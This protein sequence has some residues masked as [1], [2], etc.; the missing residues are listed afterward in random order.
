MSYKNAYL[1]YGVYIQ[2]ETFIS[3]TTANDMFDIVPL[4]RVSPFFFF[5]FFFHETSFASV[6]VIFSKY[7]LCRFWFA[8]ICTC[9]STNKKVYKKNGHIAVPL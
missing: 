8:Y 3:T 5:V 6:C 1:I 4:F 9:V 2:S 7:F